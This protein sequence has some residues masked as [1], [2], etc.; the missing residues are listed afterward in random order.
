MKRGGYLRRRTALV[1]G[2]PPVRHAPLPQVSRKRARENRQR[3]AMADQQW[4]DGRPRC[5]VPWCKRLADDLH[6]P[7]TRARGGSITDPDN[8]VPLCRPCHDEIGDEPGWAYD[9][10]LLAHSW[11]RR[12]PAQLADARRA[13]LAEVAGLESEWAGEAP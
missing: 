8:A 6:E 1:P 5:V 12:T 10:V 2:E 3:R 13:A 4:P 11:D 9:L 7:L